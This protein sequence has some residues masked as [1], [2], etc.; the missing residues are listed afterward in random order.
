MI[1]T[2]NDELGF[3]LAPADAVLDAADIRAFI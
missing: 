1:R 3:S 2:V